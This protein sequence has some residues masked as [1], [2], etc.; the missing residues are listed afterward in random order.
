ML[1]IYF[2]IEFHL[3]LISL[4]APACTCIIMREC[5]G[6]GTNRVSLPKATLII[7]TVKKYLLYTQVAAP[8]VLS[9]S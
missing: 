9:S 5:V 7:L 1:S 6:L 3:L 4:P 2:W 8:L